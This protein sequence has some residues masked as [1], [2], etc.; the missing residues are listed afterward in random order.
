[1]HATQLEDLA[2]TIGQLLHSGFHGRFDFLIGE[3]GQVRRVMSPG[4]RVKIFVRGEYWDADTDESLA[5][6]DPVE[7]TAVNG[8]RVRVRRHAAGKEGA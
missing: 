6:G 8:L 2:T 4:R 1:M 5:E 7:V 3:V